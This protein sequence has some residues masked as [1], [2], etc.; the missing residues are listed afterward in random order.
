MDGPIGKNESNGFKTETEIGGAADPAV[1][2][3]RTQQGGGIPGAEEQCAAEEAEHAEE[4][5]FQGGHEDCLAEQGR[6]S[7]E[8]FL[9]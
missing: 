7:V 2:A 4:P 6:N 5:E 9:A 8:T 3:E 1:P